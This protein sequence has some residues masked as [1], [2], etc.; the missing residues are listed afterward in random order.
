VVNGE[1]GQISHVAVKGHARK[2][3]EEGGPTSGSLSR[4]GCPR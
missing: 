2:R 4:R 3:R 1:L